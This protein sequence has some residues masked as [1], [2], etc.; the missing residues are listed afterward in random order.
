ML[1]KLIAIEKTL[2]FLKNKIKFKLENVRTL[3]KIFDLA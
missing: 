1:V 2:I 3:T